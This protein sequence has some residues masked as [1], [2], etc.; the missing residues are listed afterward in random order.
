V[1]RTSW[2]DKIESFSG[3]SFYLQNAFKSLGSKYLM[4]VYCM[5]ILIGKISLNMN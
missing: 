5:F 4:L 3:K 2:K 1:V